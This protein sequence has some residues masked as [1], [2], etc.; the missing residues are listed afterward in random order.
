MIKIGIFE[1][2]SKR[3]FMA[4]ISLMRQYYRHKVAGIS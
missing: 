2:T 4:A 3:Q 1:K